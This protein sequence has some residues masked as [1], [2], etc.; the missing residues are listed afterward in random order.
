MSASPVAHSEARATFEADRFRIVRGRGPVLEMQSTLSELSQRCGQ[1]GAMDHLEYYLARPEFASARPTLVLILGEGEHSTPLTADD[2]E[3]AVLVYEMLPLGIGCGLFS[4]DFA[5]GDRTVI[6]PGAARS[7]IAFA[8][9]SALLR[10]GGIGVEV[11]FSGEDIPRD[12]EGL[13]SPSNWHRVK[14]AARLRTINYSLPLEGSV[15]AT[16]ARMG[17]HTRRNF[18]YYRRRAEAILGHRLIESPKLTLEE[19]LA[20]NRI[21]SYPVSAELAASRYEATQSFAAGCLYLG[22]RAANGEWLS[23]LGGRTSGSKTYIEWLINRAD[24]PSYSL[25]TVMRAHLIEHQ[26]ARG[27]GQICFIY[28]TSHSMSY[29]MFPDTFVDLTVARFQPPWHLVQRIA[30]PNGAG[31]SLRQMLSNPEL[32]WNVWRSPRRHPIPLRPP[33][34][35]HPR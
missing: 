25:G 8:A 6:A 10:Q 1:A 5:G 27:A 23:L 33:A 35:V 7:R 13:Q 22:L 24:M 20:F 2:V 32:D 26:V 29:A 3:G 31:R 9:A 15:D 11:S 14:W 34:R 4:A 30:T 17:K 12:A 21:S 16:L 19:F 28:G 18:R